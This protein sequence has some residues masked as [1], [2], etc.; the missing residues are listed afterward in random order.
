MEERLY[1]F[2]SI[3]GSDLSINPRLLPELTSTCPKN[4]DVGVRLSMDHGSEDTFDIQILQN[5][6]SGF[7]VLQSDAKLMDD[8]TTRGIVDSYFG[9]L[10]P[11]TGPS[12]EADFVTSVVRMGKIGV[13]TSSNG[14]IRRVC[15]S[16]N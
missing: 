16:F 11:L 14:S 2:A 13:K 3:G 4:G 10:A 7:A 6:R 1:N 12:F 5:I 8:P 9:V 15:N